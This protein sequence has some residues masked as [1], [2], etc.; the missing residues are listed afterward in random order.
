MLNNSQAMPNLGFLFSETVWFLSFSY[1]YK[2]RKKRG[3]K[4]RMFVRNST[5]WS[6]LRILLLQNRFECHIAAETSPLMHFQ[7]LE[8]RYHPSF[9]E[10]KKRLSFS[11]SHTLS[12]LYLQDE[13]HRQT[14]TCTLGVFS[15]W[16][17]EVHQFVTRVSLG[18]SHTVQSKFWGLYLFCKWWPLQF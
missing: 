7:S 2:I 18:K 15:C 12:E 11:W 3:S 5:I 4:G 9:A 6:A 10:N 8:L 14:L 17:L 13:A 1:Q 16:V